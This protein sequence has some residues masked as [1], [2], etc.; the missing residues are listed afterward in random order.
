MADRK[1]RAN[2]NRS[3]VAKGTFVAAPLAQYPRSLGDIYR[4][5]FQRTKHWLTGAVAAAYVKL[6]SMDGWTSRPRLKLRRGQIPPTAKAMYRDMLEAFAAGDKAALRRLCTVSFAEKLES[7]ID[8]RAALGQSMRFAFADNKSSL[9]Y[10]SLRSHLISQFNPHDKVTLTEQAVVAIASTQ[11]LT[12]YKTSTGEAVPGGSKVQDKIEY[13]VLIRQVNSH[14]FEKTAWRIWG[15]TA[16]TTLEQF[17]LEKVA[18]EKEQ[19]KRAG[20]SS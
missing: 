17:D 16:A 14:T 18:M 9:F 8:R 4:Y 6:Q 5:Q 10:P 1:Q 13:V 3:R 12:R 19:R 11:T 15:T 20:W 7:A 2:A